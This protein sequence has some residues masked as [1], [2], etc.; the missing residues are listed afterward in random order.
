M[1]G[2]WH[3]APPGGA[4][5]R[6]GVPDDVWLWRG[7]FFAIESKADRKNGLSD[8][9]RYELNRIKAAGGISAAMYG[10][11]L[12]KLQ[13]IRDTIFDMTPDWGRDDGLSGEV[14]GLPVADQSRS[15]GDDPPEEDG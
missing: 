5:G 4:F 6:S 10:Y 9:Q 2:S 15:E 3:Y 13:R 8:L 11:E 12:G 7:V 1:P 14:R